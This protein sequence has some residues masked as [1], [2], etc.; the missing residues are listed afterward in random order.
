[1]MELLLRGETRR[2]ARNT[3]DYEGRVPNVY[4]VTSYSSFEVYRRFGGYKTS[5]FRV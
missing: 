2:N 1:M 3:L 4:I 5:I